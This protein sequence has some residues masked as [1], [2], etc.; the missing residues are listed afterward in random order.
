MEKEVE[1]L[2]IL[3]REYFKTTDDIQR[4]YERIWK[5]TG[6]L[7]AVLSLLFGI[8]MKE[9]VHEAFLI[10]PILIFILTFYVIM[11]FE[12]MMTTGAYGATIEEKVNGIVECNAL[13]WESKL[14]HKLHHAAFSV[15]ILMFFLFILVLYILVESLN[16]SY[17]Q[18]PILTKV[19]EIIC[20]LGIIAA[21]FRIF[22]LTKLHPETIRFIK[23]I[24]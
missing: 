6:F 21:A 9:N 11:H 10:A 23:N 13:I 15:F 19:N 2:K 8:G 22:R 3:K 16:R 17:E 12:L 5:G 14:T 20:F 1:L 24:E 4:I 18:Y 7:I